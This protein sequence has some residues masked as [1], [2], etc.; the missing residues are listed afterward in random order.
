MNRDST[1]QIAQDLINGDRQDTYG[2]AEDNFKRI[3]ERWTQLLGIEIKPW[4]VGVMMAD[5][6]LARLANG[7]P[8]LDSFIDGIGYLALAS[9]L[10]SAE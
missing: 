7:K 9:E 5:L 2:K 8:N 10:S 6:K 4:Q 1:I 3:A